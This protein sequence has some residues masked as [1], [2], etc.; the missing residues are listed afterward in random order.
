MAELNERQIAHRRAMLAHLTQL[1]RRGESRFYLI[2]GGGRAARVNYNG[3]SSARMTSSF[4]AIP[5]PGRSGISIASPSPR[6]R[7]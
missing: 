5:N 1:A 6:C 2:Q 7:R 3:N 4:N